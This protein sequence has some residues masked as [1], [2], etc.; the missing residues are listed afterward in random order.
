MSGQ[1]PEGQ[2][3]DKAGPMGLAFTQMRVEHLELQ[4]L[5][6][7]VTLDYKLNKQWG[8]PGENNR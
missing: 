8:H 7:E 6:R 3:E 2:H 1:G 5:S 4:L